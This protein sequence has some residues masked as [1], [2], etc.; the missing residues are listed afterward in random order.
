MSSHESNQHLLFLC[1]VTAYLHQCSLV[2]GSSGFAVEFPNT[3]GSSYGTRGVTDASSY[4]VAT[5]AP[6]MWANGTHLFTMGGDT[7]SNTVW[8]LVHRV[9]IVMF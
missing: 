2:A 5:E 7:N 9:R 4:P 8:W 3:F 6:A 1:L